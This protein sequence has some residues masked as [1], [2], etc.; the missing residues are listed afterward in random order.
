MSRRGWRRGSDGSSYSFGGCYLWH[1]METLSCPYVTVLAF[2][3]TVLPKRVLRT[4]WGVPWWLEEGVLLA[5]MQTAIHFRE[6]S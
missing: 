3:K 5:A 4:L 2:K 6:M 1:E